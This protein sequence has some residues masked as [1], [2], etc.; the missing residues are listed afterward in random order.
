MNLPAK[1]EPYE[2]RPVPPEKQEHFCRLISE[3]VPED[4]ALAEAVIPFCDYLAATTDSRFQDMITNAQKLRADHWFG[5][6]ISDADFAPDKDS[7]PGEKLKFER[8]KY[9][10][11]IDNPD[12][13]GPKTKQTVD[14]THN[15]QISVKNLS[16]AD[17]KK[18]LEEDPFSVPL[19]ADYRTIEAEITKPRKEYSL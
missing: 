9:L 8:L 2:V 17:A 6:I 15:I 13:Y 7:A 16:V 18:I 14:H 5:K 4:L 12:K 10:A 11:E 19:E 1:R 3:G